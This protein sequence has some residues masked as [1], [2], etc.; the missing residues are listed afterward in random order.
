MSSQQLQ[1]IF[2]VLQ[3]PCT[4]M[5]MCQSIPSVCI[6]IFFFC[7]SRLRALKERLNI[8]DIWKYVLVLIHPKY[9]MTAWF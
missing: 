3:V 7:G 2:V 5:H 4:H 8:I 9:A 1:G 6:R